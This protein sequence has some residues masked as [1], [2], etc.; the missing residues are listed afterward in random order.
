MPP[1]KATVEHTDTY[2][3][4]LRSAD[5]KIV[6]TDGT[7]PQGY[8]AVTSLGTGMVGQWKADVKVTSPNSETVSQ[9]FTFNR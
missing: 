1:G 7:D 9:A 3:A 6:E 8:T 2:S 5:G 4:V